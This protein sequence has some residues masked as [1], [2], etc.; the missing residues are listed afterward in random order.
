M[1][2]T[3]LLTTERTEISIW[4]EEDRALA[5]C[6]WGD[7]AVTHY[8]SADG[9]FTL[10]QIHERLQTEINNQIRYGVQYWP[11]FHKES[12]ELIGVCGLRPYGENA[13]ELG[14]HLR[15]C[16]HHQGYAF[17]TASAVIAYAFDTLH[18]HRLSAG[19]HPANTA[20][21]KVLKKLGFCFTGKEYYAPT[22]LFHPSY[23]LRNDGIHY[24]DDT[25][26]FVLVSELIPE[27]VYDIRYA[28]ENNF[29]G[30]PV[31]GYE[32]PC[33]ILTIQACKALKEAYDEL[34]EQGYGIRIYDGYRSQ[35]AV[36]HFMAWAADPSDIKMK[37][38]YYPGID[39]NQI[40]PQGF[41]AEHS[42][43]T[44]GSTVDLTLIDLHTGEDL[45]MGGHFD[46]FNEI[47]HYDSIQITE[48]QK[49]NR[50]ILHT[51][52]MKH[53]FMP[54]AE[55]W[56]HFTLADEPYPDTYFTFPVSRT[57]MKNR[58]IT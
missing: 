17:E 6:L 13:Y 24:S 11:V 55:E 18:A 45:D 43:H 10:Q 42:G 44:R 40:I 20:S 37:E 51:V 57:I 31:H 7:P 23:E 34:K 28:S 5:E 16:F 50:E 48:A 33:A 29:M 4:R 27:A 12:G 39:K 38:H 41:I 53:G 54:L 15:P 26:G 9:V 19:H 36:D 32:E 49:K 46:F 3:V 56:W 47:S 35:K 21:K 58:R 1:M 52:M 25:S 14:F 8:I 22:G 30:V 2:R